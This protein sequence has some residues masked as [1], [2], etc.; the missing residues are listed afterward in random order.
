MKTLLTFLLFLT[1]GYFQLVSAGNKPGK[2][3]YPK[4]N[5]HK[6]GNEFPLKMSKLNIQVEITGN[7][8][9]TTY[10]MVFI[11]NENRILE[12]E[13]EFPL[14]EGQT[15]SRFA[16]DVNGKLREG[17][18]VEKAKGRE[19]FEKIER[20][21]V[22]PGLLE[23][24]QG[25][26]FRS[27]IYPIP[28]QGTKSVTI[29]YEQEL[30]YMENKPY[31]LL[32]LQF[33][34]KIEQFSLEIE[35]PKQTFQLSPNHNEFNG[36]SFSTWNDVY[37]ARAE[38]K[39]YC[40][41]EQLAIELP[42]QGDTPEVFSESFSKNS[43]SSYF[44]V[45]LKPEKPKPVKELPGKICILW[46]AS[47]SAF[48]RDI[49][50]EKEILAGYF[51]KINNA[52]VNLVVF[53]NTPEQPVSFDIRNG[54]ASALLNYIQTT[55]FDGG[56]QL[57]AL[58]LSTYPCDEFILFS[59]G[60]SN[61]GES[62]MK[63]SE[64]P[65]IT[66]NSS[67]IADFSLLKYIAVKTGGKFINLNSETSS[68]AISDL[69]TGDYHFISARALNA[70]IAE[71]YPSIPAAFGKTFTLCGK[72]TGKKG[73]LI[74]NFG[75]GSKIMQS[76]TVEITAGNSPEKGI[77]KRMWA[78][79]AISELDMQYEKNKNKITLLGKQFG[80]VT[81]NTSLIVLETLNDYVMNEIVPPADM[82][83]AYYSTLENNNRFKNQESQ[84][85]LE[86]VVVQF[87]QR[88][89][90][91]N[92][93]PHVYQ[94]QVTV[95]SEPTTSTNPIPDRNRITQPIAQSTN[96]P[97]HSI[98]T[99]RRGTGAAGRIYGRVTDAS[100]GEPLPGVNVIISGTTI[101]VVTNIEGDYTI[102]TNTGQTLRFTYI[103]YKTEDVTPGNNNSINVA[104]AP[105]VLSLEEVVVVGYAT[106]KRIDIT[107]SITSVMPGI[108]I[109]N[110]DISNTEASNPNDD[111]EYGQKASII[112]NAWDPQA[113]YMEILK[114]VSIKEIYATYLNLRTEFEN[115][116]SFFLDVADF[117][118]KNQKPELALRVLSNLAELQ[119][120]DHQ[121][122]RVLAHRLQQLGYINLAVKTFRDV[123]KIRE[124]EPQSYRDLA[125][126]LADN[127]QPQEA[128]DI[129]YHMITKKW[130]SRFPGVE[131]IAVDEL[132]NIIARNNGKL[133]IRQIDKRLVENLP[134]DVRVVLNWDADNCD[135]DLW[136][137]SPDGEKCYYGNK[138]TRNGGQIS[139][140]FTGGYGPEEYMIKKAA[141]GQ[142]KIE[143]NYFGSRQQKIT[144][145][146]TIQVELYTHYG[147]P[148]QKKQEITMRLEEN[149]QVVQ[150]GNLEFKE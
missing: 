89:Q 69:S 79:K 10:Q 118:N 142:Y 123:L 70:N 66:I 45:V 99:M 54:N 78:E 71:T 68:E 20:R 9:T 11:N 131:R 130:D 102:N 126:A 72:M 73:K 93:T 143:V 94:P 29:A 127:K 18:V 119:T 124:E 36:L 37:K 146:T 53:R 115:S 132:N 4:I 42:Q 28:A 116:P 32:P 6:D 112:L 117:L 113:P 21:G 88:K 27:R 98:I 128:I 87:Q 63:L 3:V 14:G 56:T 40:P 51:K 149:K 103:G 85:H 1:A 44:Y 147:K 17:V 26:V 13:L 97:D 22:D 33:E 137:T 133:D 46:D 74:V 82:Q 12:G 106:Q 16:M 150:V 114:Q 49:I 35:V 120:E 76:D 48:K 8:A 75:V 43:N 86:D 5:I 15:V 96:Y 105:D 41:D 90:W 19:T 65:V 38:L 52:K 109:T 62:E 136:V 144:G 77:L 121:L 95:P 61:F 100:T 2:K 111:K 59:D 122:L 145:P 7:I 64:T 140:D 139:N 23:L 110:S 83:D 148:E 39:N 34:S 107:G 91:W 101:G 138:A 30:D 25:N 104:M 47:A 80:V 67:T 141:N 58:D 50:K 57:G 84:N 55:P 31:Y 108:K 125:L 129:L 135:M 134:V 92:I 24:T 81:R 60:M